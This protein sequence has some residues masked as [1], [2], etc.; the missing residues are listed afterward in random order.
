MM[1]YLL[2]IAQLIIFACLLSPAECV[3]IPSTVLAYCGSYLP[4]TRTYF[5][6]TYASDLEDATNSF[7][8]FLP[9]TSFCHPDGLQYMCNLLFPSCPQDGYYLSCNSLCTRVRGGCS[10]FVPFPW[11]N[12]ADLPNNGETICQVG[13]G[14]LCHIVS[15]T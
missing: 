5:P 14:L 3:E 15:S 8:Q 1:K 12:C 11:P 6:H 9:V 7:T 4:Y 2:L 13:K 10:A